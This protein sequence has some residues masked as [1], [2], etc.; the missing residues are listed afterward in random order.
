MG[1]DK[2]SPLPP[3]FV[4]SPH[5]KFYYAPATCNSMH[6]TTAAYISAFI[7][8]IVMGTGAVCF[9]VMSHKTDTIEVWMFYIQAIIVVLSVLSSILMMIGLWKEKPNLF[10]SKFAFIWFLLG[11]WETVYTKKHDKNSSC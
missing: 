4:F 6:Y 9:Y 2:I 1:H 8:F 11:V 7:E 5:D 3:N 10:I